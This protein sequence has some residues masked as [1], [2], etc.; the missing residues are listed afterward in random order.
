MT[1][2]IKNPRAHELKSGRLSGVGRKNLQPGLSARLQWLG[3]EGSGHER[4]RY[5]KGARAS[6]PLLV[7]VR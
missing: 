7:I 1:E 4:E 6:P 3:V 5:I 2:V